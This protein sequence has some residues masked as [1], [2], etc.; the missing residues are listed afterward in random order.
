[1][2]EADHLAGHRGTT[3]L[4]Q[5]LT[6]G[7]AAGRAL[8]VTGPNG[9]G[10]TTLLRMV[11]G[12]TAPTAGTLRFDGKVVRPY[13]EVLRAHVLF[14]GHAVALK[15]ELTAEENV[16]AQVRLAGTVVS[17]EGVRGALDAL[18][19]GGQRELPARVLSAGQRRRVA[20]ARL[21]LVRRR[22]WVLDEPFTALDAA[23]ATALASSMRAHL[24]EGGAAL[25]ATHQPLD[26]E[27]GLLQALA[28]APSHRDPAMPFRPSR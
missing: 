12:L 2:L 1:M 6:F 11:A 27:P 28:L 9:A 16:E 25:V 21:R 13:D 14:A 4:F 19:L 7:V 20:L 26:L 17:R 8:V 22:L 5:D 15:D 3:T 18:G 24:H 10:K 23:A